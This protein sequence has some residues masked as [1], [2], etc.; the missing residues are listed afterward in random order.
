MNEI[1]WIMRLNY[2][3]MGLDVTMVFSFIA[4]IT[5]GIG[6]FTFADSSKKTFK[7]FKTSMIILVISS[8]IRLFVPT[9]NEAMLIYGV[10][11]TIDYIKS[12]DTAKQLPD[13]YIKAL[14]AWADS[15]NEKKKED[16]K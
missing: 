12:N 11:G 8:L 2:I 13:K 10:G 15:L 3:C 1:Y 5:L 9:S 6:L 7:V 4:T 16:E 14:D